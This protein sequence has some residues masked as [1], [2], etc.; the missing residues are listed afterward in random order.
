MVFMSVYTMESCIPMKAF[1]APD[2]TVIA[3]PSGDVITDSNEL[4]EARI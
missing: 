4:P 2:F 3:I 1:E